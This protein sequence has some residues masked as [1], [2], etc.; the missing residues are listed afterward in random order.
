MAD[1]SID[2]TSQDNDVIREFLKDLGLSPDQAEIYLYLSLLGPSTVLALAK[3]IGSGRTR[4]YPLLETL[5]H[6]GLVVINEKHYGTTYEAL[7]SQSLEF[8][9]H[10]H[11]N[12]AAKLRN[13]FVGVQEA[14]LGLTGG[15]VKGSRVVEY[16]GADGLKQINFNLTKAKGEFRVFEL[17]HLDEHPGMNKSFVERLRHAFF[18]QKINSF[19]LT[20]DPDWY[21]IT[22]PQ[23]PDHKYQRGC[24]I[25]PNV[26]KIA[27]ETYVYNDCIAYLQYDQDEIFGVEIYNQ[28]LADQQKQLYDLVWKLGKEL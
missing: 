27:I 15:V 2:I 22:V 1:S 18:D 8:L 5:A 20:N 12:K 19:D 6:K 13:E 24:Y 28:S 23:D 14:L 25:D 3:A 9:V 26:F 17:A 16:K 21:F 11:E 10:E 4:L 7:S